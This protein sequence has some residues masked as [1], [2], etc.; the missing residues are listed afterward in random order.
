MEEFLSTE[1]IKIKDYKL[2]L[3]NL[4]ALVIFIVIVAAVLKLV[5]S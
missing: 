3:G 1:L 2:E 4:I 5:K